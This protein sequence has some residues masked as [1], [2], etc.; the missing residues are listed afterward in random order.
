M[1]RTSLTVFEKSNTGWSAFAL[2][3]PNTGGLG[4]TIEDTRQNLLKGIAIVL[5]DN[6]ELMRVLDSQPVTSLD[7]SEFDPD[8]IGQ[9]V[10]EWL[11]VELPTRALTEAA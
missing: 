11:D 3:F 9:Y 5:E 7:F 2:D 8:H 10:I 4:E 6:R 1:K